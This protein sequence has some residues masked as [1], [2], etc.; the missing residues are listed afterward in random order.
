MLIINNALFSFKKSNT[1]PLENLFSLILIFKSQ[2]MERYSV[3][4]G[5]AK[6][7]DESC[8]ENFQSLKFP[9]DGKN[10]CSARYIGSMV[11]DSAPYGS[12]WVGFERM[13]EFDSNIHVTRLEF[14][15]RSTM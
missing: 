11:A 14:S 4:E 3:N 9:P 10:P 1:R 13:F 6:Y 2:H 12:G 7:W 5:N 8:T 15:G